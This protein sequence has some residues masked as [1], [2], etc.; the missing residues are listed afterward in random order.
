MGLWR[1]AQVLTL[2]CIKYLGCD[3]KIW[4]G[5][6]DE[7]LLENLIVDILNGGNF[8]FKDTK[9]YQQ[10][11]YINDDKIKTVSKRSSLAQL[12]HSINEKTKYKFL[13]V[14]KYKFLLPKSMY[15]YSCSGSVPS[16]PHIL[17][18]VA[19]YIFLSIVL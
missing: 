18:S 11:K 19:V 12:F 10:I 15:K 6:V 3:S 5:Y 17:S 8:G 4:A 16:V 14:N 9:R 1:F 2:C 13:F 7:N